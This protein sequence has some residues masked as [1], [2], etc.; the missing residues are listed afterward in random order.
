MYRALAALFIYMVKRRKVAGGRPGD[1][2]RL[3][4]PSPC[5]KFMLPPSE[6]LEEAFP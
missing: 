5:L 4:G 2:R 3:A 1:S 6:G